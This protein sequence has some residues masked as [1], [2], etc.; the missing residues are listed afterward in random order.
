[1]SIKFNYETG[2][3]ECVAPLEEVEKFIN[4]E[5]LRLESMYQDTENGTVMKTGRDNYNTAKIANLNI[6]MLA[7][8]KNAE[9]FENAITERKINPWYIY[10]HTNDKIYINP[11]KENK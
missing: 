11:Y 2:I 6:A 4:G 9:Q 5:R 10:G 3:I 8:I 1:M 7:G